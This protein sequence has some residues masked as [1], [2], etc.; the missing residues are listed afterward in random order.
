MRR[1]P[2]ADRERERLV[3]TVARILRAGGSSK[4]EYE[5]ACRYG[6]RVNL[7]L[8][9]WP[10]ADADAMA[11]SIVTAGLD[12]IK[13]VRPTFWEGQP[14]YADTDTSRGFCARENCGRPVPIDLES[15]NGTP[16]KY[17]SSICKHRAHAER[18]RRFGIKASLA[19]YLAGCSAKSEQ[20]VRE[21]A[22][23]CEHCGAHF[24]TRH[25]GRKY[26]SR[27]CYAAG[28]RIHAERPCA[29]CGATFRPKNSGP[30]KGVTRYCSK[31][32]AGAARV[33]LRPDRQCPTC[34]SIFRPKYPSD[35]TRFCSWQCSQVKRAA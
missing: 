35:R 17:C 10:W 5:A 6:L 22:R 13:A 19:E 8:S 7:C 26:C 29:H 12:R 34:M 33:K 2:A 25:A 3:S 23:D 18:A 14:E 30:E 16:V 31:E 9:G 32:C 21:R 15:S 27:E 1:K 11:A 20:T 28:E 4:F 24:L